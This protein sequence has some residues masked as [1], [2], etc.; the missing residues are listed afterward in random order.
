[1]GADAKDL[2]LDLLKKT[3]SFTLWQEPGIPVELFNYKRAWPKRVLVDA[4][5]A[6]LRPVRWQIV[7]RPR[8]D[9]RQRA[10][11]QIWP[12]YADTMVGVR[13]LDNL[14]ECV[15]RVLA[16]DVPGDLIEAG[17]WRGGAS[18]FMK[19]VLTAGGDA[20]RRIFLADSFR[21]LPPPDAE[22]YPQDAG[23]KHH[24]HPYLAVGRDEVEANFAKYGLLD[25]RIV[26]LEGWF[27]DTLPAA[28]LE[29]IAVMR[30]D[31]DM[32]ES[33]MDALRHLYPKLSVGGFCVVDDYALRGCR[34][35]VDDYRRQNR[36][37]DEI[38]HIDWTGIYW[39]KQR[40]IG[41]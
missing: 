2:Y 21:G 33:T 18:I 34:Q 8:Y 10:E 39:R 9:E 28:P 35:A 41:G 22:S 23:D 19:A 37:E 14:Q 20:E 1:M 38:V 36:I 11:G 3:L 24:T 15:E 26:F 27:K 25:D 31:G 29:R 40:Q 16:D 7:E 4:L 32:Y 6:L 30:V 13:R 5:S 17:V 12:M